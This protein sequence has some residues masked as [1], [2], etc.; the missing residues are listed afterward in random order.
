MR[1]IRGRSNVFAD[2]GLDEIE[3]GELVVKADL[4]T[5]L[6]RSIR[7]RKL[8]QADAARICGTDQPTLSKTLSG[9]LDS[10]TIDRLA[11]WIVALGGQVHIKVKS[12]KER[13]GQFKGGMRVE[14]TS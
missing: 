10:I 9:K 14:G 7:S 12:P 6:M 8:K 4:V 11:R 5:L 2:I 13:G 1:A 3:A